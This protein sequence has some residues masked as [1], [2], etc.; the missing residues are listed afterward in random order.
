MPIQR[1][2]LPKMAIF[3]ICSSMA[4]ILRNI[5]LST[6]NPI[7]QNFNDQNYTYHIHD[8]FIVWTTIGKC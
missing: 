6:P 8:P 7:P 4:W 5:V 3:L 2:S 1:G